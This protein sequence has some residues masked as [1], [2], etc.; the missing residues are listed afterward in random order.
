MTFLFWKTKASC[1]RNFTDN[2]KK[3]RPLFL[4]SHKGNS[5][6]RGDNPRILKRCIY[7]MNLHLLNCFFNLTANALIR[8]KDRNV[9]LSLQVLPLKIVKSYRCSVC[10][11]LIRQFIL[12]LALMVCYWLDMQFINVGCLMV[13][14]FLINEMYIWEHVGENDIIFIVEFRGIETRIFFLIDDF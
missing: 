12:V 10:N 13:D 6:N 5:V 2:L 7:A 1:P 14:Y 8:R 11:S 9:K 4:L 3:V